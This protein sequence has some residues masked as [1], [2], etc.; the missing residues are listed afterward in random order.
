MDARIVGAFIDGGEEAAVKAA[1]KM[2]PDI[3]TG[4][5]STLKVEWVE[6]GTVFEI[7]EYDGSESLNII[8]SQSYYRA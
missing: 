3:Y 1:L 8:G 2:F 6:K 5:S 4:G 7:R